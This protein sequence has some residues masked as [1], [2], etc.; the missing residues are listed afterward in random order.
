MSLLA[1]EFQRLS[2]KSG[3]PTPYMDRLRAYLDPACP[4]IEEGS[5]EIPLNMTGLYLVLGAGIATALA[6]W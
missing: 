6:G 2:Q 4:T 5:R 1:D 3:E